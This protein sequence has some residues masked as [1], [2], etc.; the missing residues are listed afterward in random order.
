MTVQVINKD[1]KTP[2][3]KALILLNAFRTETDER[4]AAKVEVPKGEYEFYVSKDNY[5]MFQTS[6]TV[7][8]DVTIKVELVPNPY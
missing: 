4:G 2:V 6:V 5:D 8:S 3:N 1:T 7:A